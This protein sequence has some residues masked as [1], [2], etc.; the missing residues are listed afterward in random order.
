M[1]YP[2]N[3]ALSQ[4]VKD[5]VISTFRQTLELHRQGRRDEV[6]SGCNLMLQMDPA[7]EPAR[8]LL[9][10]SRNPSLPIDVEN[11][12]TAESAGTIEQA[13]QAMASRDFQRVIQITTEILTDDLMNDEARVL[14]DEA[15]DKL[16]ASPFVDQ[17]AR[18][19][20]QL[21]ASG[22]VAGAKGELEKARALDPTHPDVIRIGRELVARDSAAA[23][24]DTPR[25]AT[26]GF[27]FDA[28]PTF[29]VDEPKPSPTT[30][31]AAQASDFGFTFEEDKGAAASPFANFSFDAAPS[32]AAA[33][34][35]GGGFSFD[36]PSSAPSAAPPPGDFDFATAAITTTP[37]DQKKIDQYLAD[38]DRAFGAGD[39]QQAIDLWSRIFLIDVTNDAASDRI[40]GAKAKRREVEDRVEILLAS[41]VSAFEKRDK[42]KARTDFAEVLRIDPGNTTARD[43]MERL[44]D[45]G[46]GGAGSEAAYIPPPEDKPLGLDFLDE[47]SGQ[48]S[49]PPLMPPGSGPYDFEEEQEEAR[50]KAKGAKQTQIPKAKGRSGR[51][52]PIGAIA[53]VLGVL[54]LGAG[55]W[56]AWTHFMTKPEADPAATQAI[57]SRAGALA[58]NGKYEQAIK[59]LQDVRPD[60]PE[61]DKALEMIADMQAKKSTAAQMIEGKPAAQYYQEKL[62]AAAAAYAAH[63]YGAAKQ[64]LEDA[65][66]VKPLPPD[67]KATYDAATQQVAKLDAAKAL[68]QERKYTEALA[69]LTTLQSQDPENATIRR[70]ITDAHFNL[71]ATALQSAVETSDSRLNL[72]EAVKQ[73]DEV[74]KLNPNDELARRSRELGQR[75][76]GRPADLL[77]R[78]Y[79]KYLPAR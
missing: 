29:V 59:L 1:S 35:A 39:Y 9:D 50:P 42:A 3:A 78:I 14:G 17:F 74:L 55:G 73:F 51:K 41:A 65:T 24:L 58:R 44:S 62:D 7:F 48:L 46:E 13:R 56:Y 52:L 77:F 23:I 68:M 71:G 4:A 75:Y 67:V 66:K 25:P 40:E 19:C 20:D 6:A 28:N 37:E 31:P 43:F 18:K 16:E 72:E 5:R 8:K 45:T 26:G 47:D 33:P 27:N 60:D 21:L 12:L 53:A 63:D 15:R 34:A 69:D 57:F 79:V 61:H 32:A 49:E 10:K 2:G 22:N 30:R 76:Q 36:A 64:L 38:G 70:M 11:L 54:I